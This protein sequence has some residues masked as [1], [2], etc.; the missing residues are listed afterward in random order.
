MSAWIMGAAAADFNLI[1][2]NRG[3]RLR[4][5]PGESHDR[6]RPDRRTKPITGSKGSEALATWAALVSACA[7]W[8]FDAMD[9]QIFTLILFPSVSDLVESVN[10]GVVAYTGGIIVGWKL[11]ALGLGGIA[12]GVAVDRIGRARTMIVTVLIYSTFTGLSALAQSWG[13]L[14]I[15][16]S[17]AGIGI[18]GEWAAGAALVA[19][20]WPERRVRVRWSSCRCVLRRVSS[21]QRLSIS[22][23]GRSA[24]GSFR[25]RCSTSDDHT[26]RPPACTRTVAMDHRA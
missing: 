16:Q 5:K 13:Q 20:S 15:L 18:G 7:A 22:S 25:C 9:L 12:F 8:M 19:E 1:A 2:A 23:L 4:S 6:A 26:V 24:G 10:P 17:L 21:W 14:A 11:V 3:S